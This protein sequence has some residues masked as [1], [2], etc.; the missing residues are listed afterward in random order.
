MSNKAAKRKLRS[1][2]VTTVISISL[3]LFLLGIIG[4]LILNARRL[5]TYVRENLGFTVLINDNSRE[6]EVQRLQKILNASP[7]VRSASYISK[8]E[9]ASIMKEELG[10][11][12]VDFLGYNPL[13]SSIEVKVFA[14]YANPD[15][16]AVIENQILNFPQV[17]EVYYQK[18]LLHAVN[19][20]I[21]KITVV[22]GAFVLLLMII[23]IALINNTIRLSVYSRRF[24]IKTMQLVGAT[25]AFIRKPFLIKGILHGLAGAT[26]A[27]ILLSALIYGLNKELEGMIGFDSFWLIGTLFGIVIVLGILISLISTFF[28]VNK[29]LRLNAD[30]L[31]Y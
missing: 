18:N 12:F 6:A 22:L 23:S 28:A 5:S 1:S 17:K 14:E 19:D 20:N 26:V 24:L 2:Y 7:Y 16:M 11:D 13:L 31:Y 8:D 29:Y 4:L 15:S 9:A 27:I 3:V 10:E 21:E 30:E 25:R